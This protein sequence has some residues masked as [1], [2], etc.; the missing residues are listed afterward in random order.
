VLAYQKSIDDF[1]FQLSVFNSYSAVHFSPDQL[2]DLFL[3]V[4]LGAWIGSVMSNGLQFDS[5]YEI[6]ESH[7]LRGGVLL[8]AQGSTQTANTTV[9][10]EDSVTGSQNGPP[11]RFIGLPDGLQYGIYLQD[12][13][14]SEG[15]NPELC[16]RFDIYQSSQIRQNQISPRINAIYKI[17]RARQYMAAMPVIY[18]AAAENVPQ[19]ASIS[20]LTRP[21]RLRRA[22]Q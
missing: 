10:P 6:D 17:A 19:A 22:S 2:G 18:A 7:T 5:S 21:M 3:M 15:T 8:N 4:S 12:E 13:W 9:I 1:N 14:K 20:S 16:G 11:Q